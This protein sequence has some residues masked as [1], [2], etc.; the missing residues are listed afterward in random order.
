MSTFVSAGQK[1][2]STSHS[3]SSE[4]PLEPEAGRQQPRHPRYA[5]VLNWLR[6]VTFTVYR[7]LLLILVLCNLAGAIYVSVQGMRSS[8]AVVAHSVTAALANLTAAVLIRQDYVVNGLYAICWSVPHSA[9][10]RFRRKMAL[11]Y[12]NG[13][14]HS[15]SALGALI[16]TVAFL[17]LFAPDGVRGSWRSALVLSMSLILLTLLLLVILGALPQVRRQHHNFFENTHRIGGWCS[18]LLF[19]PTL[20]LFIVG[21]VEVGAATPTSLLLT[22]LRTPA[23]WMLL[24][25]SMHIVYPWL[26]LRK[27]RVVKSEHLSDHAVRIHFDPRERVRPLRGCAISDAPLRE[28]HSFAMIPDLD[29]RD[30]GA[31]SCIISKAGDWT[32]K[33]IKSPPE[34]FYMRG[35]PRTGVLAMAKVFKS[36]V[37]MSTGSGIGPCLSVLGGI[38]GTEVRIIW[39]APDPLETFG[40]RIYERVLHHDPRAM[41]L[42]TRLEGHRRPDLVKAALEVYLIE[43]AEAVFFISNRN[44]T[45][46]VT[47]GLASKGVPVFAP[48]FDS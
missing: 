44:L 6:L 23:S 9:P 5:S 18:V 22:L 17:C 41:I 30:G 39:S 7:Q 15:G 28:W 16:W 34:Y 13:G 21:N 32:S 42:D 24:I 46:R 19:W 40:K 35:L 48:V 45:H 1:P 11:I 27:V 38:P 25:I 37:L 26:L 8:E 20:W 31:S 3:V 4:L 43:K 33:V 2:R 36:I 12:E 14:V 29:S 10:L 47:T